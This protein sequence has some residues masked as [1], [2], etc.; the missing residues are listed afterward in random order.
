MKKFITIL[1]DLSEDSVDAIIISTKT[2]SEQIQECIDKAKSD[3]DGSWEWNDI[4]EALPSDC[5]V[6]DRWNADGTVIY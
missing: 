3:N 2:T 5:T 6:Y 1:K 4:V